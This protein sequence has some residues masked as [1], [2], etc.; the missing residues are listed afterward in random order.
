MARLEQEASHPARCLTIIGGAARLIDHHGVAGWALAEAEASDP[1][2]LLRARELALRWNTPEANDG[3][4]PNPGLPVDRPATDRCTTAPL[5]RQYSDSPAMPGLLGVLAL[6]FSC[7]TGDP[8]TTD[9]AR[10]ASSPTLPALLIGTAA[11]SSE[12]DSSDELPALELTEAEAIVMADQFAERRFDALDLNDYPD[13]RARY[14]ASNCTWV[15]LYWRVPNRRP[16]DHF[17]V[18]INTRTHKLGFVPGM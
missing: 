4:L 15:V 11:H 2:V 8:A 1:A 9:C 14:H 5:G 12:P 13:R 16:G 18:V 3:G 17:L 10:D 6:L 7:A